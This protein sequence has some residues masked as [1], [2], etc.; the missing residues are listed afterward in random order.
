[1]KAIL[2]ID[3][4][5]IRGLLPAL[6][7]AQ[8]E[9]RLGR[10]IAQCFDLIAGTSTGG[11]LAL[12]LGKDNGE[13]IPQYSAQALADMY[14]QHGKEIFSRSLW[15]GVSSVG[16]LLDE[17]YSHTGLER[18]LK[19][20]FDDE[21]LGASLTRLLLTSYDIH[22]RKPLFLKSWRQEHRT[23]LMRHA[24]RATSAAPTYFEPAH[25]PVDG[26]K[27]ALVDGGVFINS[28]SVSAYAE[29]QR[30]FPEEKEFLLVS[31]GTG[32]LN[33]PIELRDA[34]DWGKA[35]WVAPLLSCIFDGVADAADYQMDKLLGENYYRLQTTLDIASDD[36]DDVTRGNIANLK[37]EAARLLKTSAAE[38]DALCQRL[39]NKT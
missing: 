19:H 12:G 16:G 35:G 13:G 17:T 31:I 37:S 29:A 7:L 22:N 14:E 39:A 38:L 4:G 33:R 6:V 5:G 36:M 27:R 9:T 24:A 1:M 20:Y 10:P 18:L 34:K 11:I 3:G 32:E 2:S 23:V 28:P 25:I 26:A 8:I 15:R 30:I 21:P